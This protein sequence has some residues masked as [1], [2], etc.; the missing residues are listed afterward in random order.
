MS[1]QKW[2]ES[3]GILLQHYLLVKLTLDKLTIEE[4]ASQYNVATAG[5]DPRQVN[6]YEKLRGSLYQAKDKEQP[7]AMRSDDLE[8]FG[9]EMGR[10]L[11]GE[12]Q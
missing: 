12:T 9:Q 4:M 7:P 5:W 3:H 10:R 11:D 1:V 6:G 8:I 2:C